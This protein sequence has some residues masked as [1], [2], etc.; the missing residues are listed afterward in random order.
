MSDRFQIGRKTYLAVADLS[1]GERRRYQVYDPTSRAMRALHVLSQSSETQNRVRILQRLNDAN[2]ELPQILEVH[3]QGNGLWLVLPW[4][5]GD[6]LRTRLRQI[7][8]QKKRPLGTPESVRL[9]RS[10]AHALAHVHRHRNIIHGDIKPAN[11][12]IAARSRKLVLIDYGSAWGVERSTTRTEGD[13][14]S[15]SYAA[16]E[17]LHGDDANFRSDHFS[18]A[19]VCYEMLTLEVPYNGLGGKAGL[20]QFA[21]GADWMPPSEI[22][23]DAQ[24]IA[25]SHWRRIDELLGRALSLDPD[26]RFPNEGDWLNAWDA[27][28]SGL[29]QTGRNPGLFGHGWLKLMEWVDTRR[30]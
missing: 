24:R 12:L 14:T 5:E 10:M 22:G 6:D 7:R 19:A 21:S 16:P 4:I 18:L 2:P 28:H 8:E 27:L 3:R 20:A 1:R 26:Q 17:R 15:S 9:I 23:V 29:R 30:H 13:G 11:L 25:R